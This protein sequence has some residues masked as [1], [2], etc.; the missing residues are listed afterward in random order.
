MKRVSILVGIGLLLSACDDDDDYYAG[1]TTVVGTFDGLF[2]DVGTGFNFPFDIGIV[3]SV[4]NDTNGEATEGDIFV[5]SYGTSEIRRVQDP[6][7]G[8]ATSI[9][10]YEGASDGLL[11]AMAVSIPNDEVLWAAFE[12]GG[13]DDQGGIVVMAHDGTPLNVLDAAVDPDAFANPGGLCF[14]GWNEEESLAWFFL[15]NFGDGTAWRISTS[16][17]AANDVEFV[18]VGSGLATATPGNPGTPGNELSSSGDTPDGGARGCAYTNG[19]LYVAD[20]QNA[21]VVRFDGAST[22]TD[23]RG[24]ALEDTPAELVTFPTDLSINDAGDLIVISF[25]NAHAF[26]SLSLPSGGF[27]D[28][29][30]HDL[31]VNSG[32][33]GVA[34]AQDTIWFTRANNSN[35][36]LRAITPSQNHQPNTRGPFP[37]Q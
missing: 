6:S 17:L 11:G 24:V 19:S 28:N 21:R 22:G 37:A 12:Q 27:I 16:N 33:Y 13:T 1:D 18:Q 31:N 4:I 30:L 5:A 8:S 34:V 36:T 9:S 26:V 3:P 25:D 20:A 2:D 35:G 10:V 14:G 23:I 29:G 15:V 7:G 32:N